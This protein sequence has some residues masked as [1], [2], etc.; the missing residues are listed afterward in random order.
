[1]WHT[2]LSKVFPR[3]LGHMQIQSH[4]QRSQCNLTVTMPIRN[5]HELPVARVASLNHSPPVQVDMLVLGGGPC[6]QRLWPLMCMAVVVKKR[7][8]PKWVAMVNGD[9]DDLTCGPVPGGLILTHTHILRRDIYRV[10]RDRR[11]VLILL[12]VGTTTLA[13]A[14]SGELENGLVSF[15]GDPNVRLPF[16]FKPTPTMVA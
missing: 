2:G 12:C 7:V 13:R 6:L 4:S 1:M 3:C 16:P 8:P 11:R 14:W 5:C 9:T 10:V 15:S